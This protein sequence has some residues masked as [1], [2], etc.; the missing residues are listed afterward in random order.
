MLLSTLCAVTHWILTTTPGL[1]YD[2]CPH[3]Y[4]W[5][6]SAR[7][8]IWVSVLSSSPP[9]PLRGA[10]S[11]WA[12]LEPLRGRGE[13]IAEACL[14]SGLR[15]DA[16]IPLILSLFSLTSTYLLRRGLAVASQEPDSSSVCTWCGR[17]C[18]TG[19]AHVTLFCRNQRKAVVLFV[20]VIVWKVLR[21]QLSSLGKHIK[22]ANKSLWAA[23][24]MV[25]WIIVTNTLL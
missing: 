19:R 21:G 9:Y 1:G 2:Y 25:P 18:V 24:W 6:N 13:G 4:R 5:E 17:A 11:L 22:L 14:V 15:R 20:P 10:A 23:H 16:G 3:F 12:L 8:G 7:L